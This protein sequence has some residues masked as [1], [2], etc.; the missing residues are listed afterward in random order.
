MFSL[1]KVIQQAARSSE[2]SS[3]RLE[4]PRKLINSLANIMHKVERILV[5]GCNFYMI[6]CS[7]MDAC[8][9]N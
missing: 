9:E 6:L 8:K 5:I 7:E 2:T 1:V 4:T 3:P